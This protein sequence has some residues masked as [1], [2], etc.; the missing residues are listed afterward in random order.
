MS[1]FK[2]R[3]AGFLFIINIFFAPLVFAEEATQVLPEKTLT[4]GISQEFASLNPI[5]N[6]M[7]ASTYILGL[8]YRPLVTLDADWQWKAKIAK[9][10]PT[11]ENGQAKLIEENGQK[12]IL[13]TWEIKENVK[14]G[15]GTPVTVADFQLGWEVGKSPNVAM[16]E[17]E[18]FTQVEEILPDPQN[19]RRFTLKFAKAQYDHNFLPQFFLLPSHLEKSVWEKTKNETGAYEKQTLYSTDPTDPGLYNG[20]YVVQE[21]KMGSHVMLKPNPHFYGKKPKIQKIIIKLIQDT[22]TIEAN[23]L[24]GTIDMICELGLNFDQAASL[25]KRIEQDPALKERFKVSFFDSVTYEHIDLNL[26]NPILKDLNV[27]RALLLSVDRQKLVDAMFGGRQK[28]ALHDIHPMD[29]YYTDDVTRYNY[30]PAKAA[31]LLEASGWKMGAEGYRTKNGERLSFQIMTT[32]GNKTRE[33]VQIFLQNEWKKIGIELKIKNEPARVYFGETVRKAQYPHLAMYATMSAPDS[34]PRSSLY[35]K[36]IPTAENSWSGQNSGGWANEIADRVFEAVYYEFDFDKRKELMKQLQQVYVD[37]VP[38][39]P[40]YLRAD[41]VVLPTRLKNYRVT[42]HQ[43]YST[44][45]AEDWE[46]SE[47]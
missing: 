33:L 30:D 28:V 19:P 5:I 44:E 4:I 1:Q 7:V 42:G 16:G 21:I 41:I 39:M 18:T 15:D 23:L 38:V 29:P 45:E 8:V 17:K 6:Q 36:N 43:F 20:P 34:P 22:S 11:L 40:L 2:K 12:K 10:I 47:P 37:E 9:E 46:L 26:R 13:A 31:T 24:S 27:R 25:E 35:S 32:A 14:W 3:W